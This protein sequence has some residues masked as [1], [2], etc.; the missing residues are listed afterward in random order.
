MAESERCDLLAFLIEMAYI[1]VSD[2][3][4]GQRPLRVQQDKRHSAT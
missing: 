1:E 4:R 2:I 3:I